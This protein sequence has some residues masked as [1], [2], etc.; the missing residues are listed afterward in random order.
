MPLVK[1]SSTTGRSRRQGSTE[2]VVEL[3]LGGDGAVGDD[4]RHLALAARQWQG[5]LDL[6]AD[7]VG[8]GDAAVDLRAGEVHAVVVVPEQ[9]GRLLVGIDVVR[10]PV[11]EAAAVGAAVVRRPV[12]GGGQDQ[13]GGVAVALRRG[14]A[15]VEV[16]DDRGPAAR[17]A[18][19]RPPSGRA[20]P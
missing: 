15:P 1:G 10:D 12:S 13:V 4:E 9:G 11:G 14:H 8:P 2:G 18:G 5:V 6:V 20:A 16:G 19:G 3:A 7:D 17:S